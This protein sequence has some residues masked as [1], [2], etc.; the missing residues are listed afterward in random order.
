MK[1]SHRISFGI[2]EKA[3]PL[4]TSWA[5]RLKSAK[6][7]GFDFVEMSLDP[8]LE[9]LERLDWS[10]EKRMELRRIVGDSGIAIQTMCLSANRSFPIGS[11]E[12]TV[13]QR[14]LEIVRKAIDL[15]SD[16]GIR[17]VQLAGYDNEKGDTNQQTQALYVHGIGQAVLWAS[18][19]SVLLG[20]ENQE[21]GYV[22]S[23]TTAINIINKIRSPYLS[24]YMDVGNLVV[25][26]FDVLK[27]IK[28]AKGYL[29]GIHIKDARLGEP[30]RVPFAQGEVPFDKIFSQ[31][32]SYGF[33]GPMM[34]EMWNDD[35]PDSLQICS[36][37]LNWL[38]EELNKQVSKQTITE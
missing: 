33:S 22:D 20:L 23:P 10:K 12:K 30:R 38:K 11:T 3:L 4:K 29:C 25:K 6:D 35:S 34:I 2:Y 26:E 19:Q 28:I 7:I 1:E 16:I 15:A 5:D 9:R 24:L 36:R 18:K 21:D 27:E 14:G 17:I 31:L 8:S 13:R 32:F 37:A